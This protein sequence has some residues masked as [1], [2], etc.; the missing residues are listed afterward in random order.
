MDLVFEPVK[1]ITNLEEKVEKDL[2]QNIIKDSKEVC[3]AKTNCYASMVTAPYKAREAVVKS[4]RPKTSV[5]SKS[6][7]SSK[8]STKSVLRKEKYYQYIQVKNGKLMM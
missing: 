8:S 5:K 4:V 7:A 6:S 1:K 2:K 3:K